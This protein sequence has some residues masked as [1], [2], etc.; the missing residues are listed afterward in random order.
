MKQLKEGLSQNKRW[1][2]ALDP[3]YVQI[4]GHSFEELVASSVDFAG[5][6]NFYETDNKPY[7]TWKNLLTADLTVVLSYIITE[8]IKKFEINFRKKEELI[9]LTGSNNIKVLVQYY[10]DVFDLIIHMARLFDFWIIELRKFTNYESVFYD[11]LEQAVK[12]LKKSYKLLQGYAYGSERGKDIGEVLRKRF[13]ELRSFKLKEEPIADDS[14][15]QG[16]NEGERIKHALGFV[17]SIFNSFYDTLTYVKS[18]APK[19]LEDSLTRNNHHPQ[20][21]LLLA[22]L[23]LYQRAQNNLNNIKSR[24]LDFYYRDVLQQVPKKAIPDK[25]HV[26]FKLTDDAEF[27]LIPKGAR[28]LAGKDEEGNIRLYESDDDV[29]LNKAVIQELRTLYVSKNRYVDVGSNEKLVSGIYEARIPEGSTVQI[30]EDGEALSWPTLG[31]DQVGVS[32]DGRTMKDAT[33]GFAIASPALQLKEG[34]REV[35]I[36][37]IF[38]Q[39]TFSTFKQQ[40]TTISKN[41]SSTINEVFLKVFKQAFHISI[42]AEEGWLHINKYGLELSFLEDGNEKDSS[43]CIH[44]N[45]S[46]DDPGLINN[47][48]DIHGSEF[49]SEWPIVQLLLNRKSFIY[50]YSL[51]SGLV[52][53]E[54]GIDTQVDEVKDISVYNDLGQLSTGEPFQPFGPMPKRGSYMLI[55]SKEVLDKAV[56]DVTLKLKW[57]GLPLLESGLTEYYRAYEGYDITNKS[58][59][60]EYSLL[61]DGKWLFPQSNEDKEHYLFETE[62]QK[63]GAEPNILSPIKYE[64]TLHSLPIKEFKLLPKY[65]ASSEPMAYESTTKSGFIK[66]E[67]IGEEVMFGHKK[68]PFIISDVFIKNA[69]IKKE[70]KRKEIPNEPYTPFL[71]SIQ[72]GYRDS[73]SIK[74]IS[75]K[76]IKDESGIGEVF[77]ITPFQFNKKIYPSVDNKPVHLIPE[78]DETG[79]LFIGLSNF[80]PPDS[81]TLFFHLKS[82]NV[83]SFDQTNSDINWYYLANNEWHKLEHYQ[84]LM[85]STEGLLR[86]GIVTLEIPQRM[87]RNNTILEDSVHWLKVTASESIGIMG[88]TIEIQTQAATLSWVAESSTDT[89]IA[90]SLP[91]GTISSLEEPIPRIATTTQSIESFGGK[92]KEDDK[93]FYT[94]TGERLRH[95]NRAIVSRDYEQLILDKFPEIFKVNCIQSTVNGHEDLAPGNVLI[96]VI[97]KVIEGSKRV[98]LPMANV[99]LLRG[100]RK[101]IQ[102]LA[103]PFVNVEVRNPSY[104]RV[105][106]ICAVRF[107]K[108]FNN[109]QTIKRLDADLKEFLSPWFYDAIREISFGGEIHVSDISGFIQSRPYIDFITKLSLLQVSE[110]DDNKYDLNDTAREENKGFT[111]EV[112][113]QNEAIKATQMWSVLVSAKRHHIEVLSDEKIIQA[114]QTGI[115]DLE[116]GSSFIID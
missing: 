14:I 53:Q 90:E 102:K 46:T 63:S 4:D 42:T 57:L 106:V 101:Y 37:I 74:F 20:I 47:D 88:E 24:H 98:N 109:G 3:D 7:G 95:K 83:A 30:Q 103:S 11:E 26:H 15:Y 51:M 85:D 94:R 91:S 108:G 28:F 32:S 17:K 10:K 76:G 48:K 33:I 60:I 78:F 111:D 116:L 79:S 9:E 1:L 49:N 43:I 55:G 115:D 35:Q 70:S 6:L 107:I 72:I 31:E 21:G 112:M 77:H 44:F 75:Q 50:P 52:L 41:T 16:E 65:H 97:P 110:Y 62:D 56:N 69:Q 73:K 105:R 38:E 87:N 86:S 18:T 23:K 93:Q 25:V 96:A 92:N 66:L 81:L 80:N 27:V 8:D 82:K 2:K 71:S 59:K 67:L 58:F 89:H 36:K 104:E 99:S 22:F 61:K 40:I 100:I 13:S 5:L 39:N 64:T 68:Y 34:Q 114:E 12:E 84:V 19:Y 54:I 45:L 113:D 29:R